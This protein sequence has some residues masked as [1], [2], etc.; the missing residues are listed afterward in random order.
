M[1][2]KAAT[3]PPPSMVTWL[4]GQYGPWS[5]CAVAAFLFYSDAKELSKNMLEASVSQAKATAT[6]VVT[7]D[8]LKASID[9]MR[10]EAKQ[11]HVA[12]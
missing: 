10:Q 7:L 1:A 6:L 8:S 5:L 9:G 11:A 12:R 2:P 3:T 4:L